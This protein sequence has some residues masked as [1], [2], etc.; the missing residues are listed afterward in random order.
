MNKQDRKARKE[1][2][3]KEIIPFVLKALIFYVNFKYFVELLPIVFQINYI[4]AFYEH[5]GLP[6]YIICLS[7]IICLMVAPDAI[8]SIFNPLSAVLVIAMVCFI[9]NAFIIGILTFIIKV[10]T[11]NTII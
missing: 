11:K 3:R 8:S 1:A 7:M 9:F 10:I 5:S 4:K 2:A 6:V